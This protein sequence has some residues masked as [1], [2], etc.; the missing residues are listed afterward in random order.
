MYYAIKILWTAKFY[1]YQNINGPYNEAAW[2]VCLNGL[3]RCPL[4]FVCTFSLY[5][6]TS[7][8]L[9]SEQ[10][11]Y[12]MARYRTHAVFLVT[13]VFLSR[14]NVVRPSIMISWWRVKSL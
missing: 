12:L 9:N 6:E 10:R 7:G 2:A 13:T 11:T 14:S 3:L 5:L 8:T 1:E 4:G